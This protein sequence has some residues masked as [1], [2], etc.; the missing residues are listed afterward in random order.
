MKKVSVI[1]ATFNGEKTIE[2]TVESIL[3]QDGVTSEF[4]IELIVV[5]DCSTDSTYQKLEKFNCILLQNETN[6]GGPNKGR[7]IGLDKATGDYVCIADQDDIWKSDRI[8]TLLPYLE[9]VPIVSSGYEVLDKQLGKTIKRVKPA[10]KDHIYYGLN[11]TFLKRLRRELDGQ[12]T[13]LGSII[14]NRYKDNPESKLNQLRFEE[15]FGMV[16]YDWVLKLFHENDSIEV[17][18]SLYVRM[19]DG[20]NLSLNPRYRRYDYY[21][22]LLTLDGYEDEYTKSVYFAYK[23]IHGSRAR[24]FYKIGNR[25]KARYFFLKA[26]WDWKTIMYFLTSYSDRAS[27]FVIKRFNVFG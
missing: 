10:E 8:R 7:N 9:R 27:N 13:Y 26:H 23:K 2:R 3:G 12:N 11:Q 4:L 21:F 5:D 6:S 22:S 19:V 16:D 14:Y 15:N 17:C 1:L 20:Q 18:K 24:Y 25:K